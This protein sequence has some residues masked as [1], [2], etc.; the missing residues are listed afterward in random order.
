MPL[1]CFY[2]FI[3]QKTV[4]KLLTVENSKNQQLCKEHHE[5]KRQ[6][7]DVSVLVKEVVDNGLQS[8]AI[9]QLANAP[10][11]F[12]EREDAVKKIKQKKGL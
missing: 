11:L 9:E 6:N 5:L 8:K 2:C 3:C 12:Q 1:Y 7:S 4:K 10:D